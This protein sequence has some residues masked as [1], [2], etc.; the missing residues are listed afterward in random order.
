MHIFSSIFCRFWRKDGLVEEVVE[1]V[2]I[3]LVADSDDEEDEDEDPQEPAGVADDTCG[4]CCRVLD[5][6]EVSLLVHECVCGI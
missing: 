1:R 5:D 3:N 4:E 6:E 2:F